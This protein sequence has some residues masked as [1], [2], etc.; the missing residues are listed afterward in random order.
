[1][2][3]FLDQ[4]GTTELGMACRLVTQ[5]KEAVSC[6]HRSDEREEGE[7]RV[8]SNPSRKQKV[9]ALLETLQTRG[10]QDRHSAE[11]M[12]CNLAEEKN[13]WQRRLA[14]FIENEIGSLEQS[15][16]RTNDGK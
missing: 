7:A 2:L 6:L 9:K 4:L 1:M 15:I 8:R 5:W 14:L 11:T 10:Y 12:T 3:G 13:V 16:Q